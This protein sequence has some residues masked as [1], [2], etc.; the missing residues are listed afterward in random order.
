[1]E[2][3]FNYQAVPYG[4]TH[5]FNACCP[6]GEKC[7]HRLVA[8]HSTN[9]Y[10]TLSVVN[11]NCIPEDAKA[12]PFYSLFARYVWHGVSGLC[13]MMCL[14][15]MLYPLKTVCSN[16]S[17]GRYTIAFIV[18]NTRLTLNNRNLSVD[19]FVRKVSRKSRHLSTTQKNISGNY[20]PS[21][22]NRV[23]CVDV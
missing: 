3:E 22:T 20:L 2:D 1:M 13:W 10:P 14:S 5:C 15:K 16:I 9:Q 7:L 4:Y 6:K 17:D 12:C 21:V 19:C 11:P 8:V 23:Y 18:K